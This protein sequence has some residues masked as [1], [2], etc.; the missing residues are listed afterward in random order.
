MAVIRFPGV[1]TKTSGPPRE[2]RSKGGTFLVGPGAP[3]IEPL[4]SRKNETAN[5]DAVR[6]Q[7][8]RAIAAFDATKHNSIHITNNAPNIFRLNEGWSAQTGAG[9]FERAILVAKDAI[10]KSWRLEITNGR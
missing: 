4:F 9:F 10:K 3:K 5:L 1:H 7:H 8:S 2:F 6:Q